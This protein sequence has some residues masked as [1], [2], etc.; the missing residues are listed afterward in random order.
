[1]KSIKTLIAIFALL[2]FTSCNAQIK[3]LK[4]ETVKIYG[5]CGMCESTIESTGNLKKVASVDWNQDTKMAIFKYDSTKTNQDEILKRI[6]R[7][8]YDSDK[9]L[10]PDDAYAKLPTCCQYDRVNKKSKTTIVS[11][12]TNNNVKV[13][14]TLKEE[15]NQLVVIYD[16]YFAIKDALVQ[17]NG[18]LAAE[19]AAALNSAISSIKMEKLSTNEHEVWMKVKD[20][21]AFNAQHIAETKE[22]EH[23][24]IHFISLSNGMYDLIKVSNPEIPVYYQFCPM[25]NDGKGANWL[26]KE[27]TIK[28]PY[29]GS[30]MLT[31]GKTVETIK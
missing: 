13:D 27:N 31:C 29:Y 2:S 26:S 23:Q 5:N 20:D 4:T 1:M 10:A 7:A 14:T 22:V 12:T 15:T 25:A 30:T 21:L 16:L 24:R 6:A 17:S 9:F 19:K 28:N 8:G 18:N 11:T 3:N